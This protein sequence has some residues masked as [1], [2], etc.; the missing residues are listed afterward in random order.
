MPPSAKVGTAIFLAV[1][2]IVAAMKGA[3]GKSLTESLNAG[4]IVAGS[5]LS[6]VILVIIF[7]VLQRL[8]RKDNRN[9]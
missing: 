4:A 9:D 8:F 3:S 2:L 7:R 5:V 1:V 6:L